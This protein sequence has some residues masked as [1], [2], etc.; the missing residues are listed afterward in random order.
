M[1][2]SQIFRRFVG[3]AIMLC[4]LAACGEAPAPA[5][6]LGT[7]LWPGYEP[8]YLARE[9]GLLDAEQ[10]VLVE[11]VN[12]NDVL[13][14]M[15][16]DVLDAG[17]LTMDEVLSL[18]SQRGDDEFVIFHVADISHGSDAILARPPIETIEQLR[19]Q[20]IGYE[21]TALGSYFLDRA[22]D[23]VPLSRDDFT[24]VNVEMDKQLAAWERGDI[25]AVATFEP[26]LTRFRELGANVLFSSADIPGE[27]VDVMVVRREVLEQRPAVL[28]HLV[29]AWFAAVQI[30]EQDPD[31]ALPILDQRLRL[32]EQGIKQ[33]LSGL[34]IPS[35][36]EV[37]GL[38]TGQQP[39]LMSAMQRMQGV[40][41]EAG[42]LQRQVDVK[43]LFS[44]TLPGISEP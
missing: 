40:M 5:L 29:S 14:G 23:G 26:L 38:I 41:T 27:I 28:A 9:Q 31:T 21:I 43:L 34:Q 10:V 13:R 42:L 3:A 4:G 18:A 17:A 20:R 32:G 24:A 15:L 12:S 39:E 37:A 36:S 8:I 44:E 1:F 33:A 35:R 6:R 22:L 30:L 16:N 25:D 19:G 2:L 7:I 11:Y